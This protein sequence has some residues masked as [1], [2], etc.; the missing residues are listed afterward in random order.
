MT[1]R[2]NRLPG[3]SPRSHSDDWET[4]FDMQHYGI[5]TRLLDWSENLG[6]AAFF[7]S[8]FRSRHEVGS[9]IAIYML[10]P[11]ILN[12]YSGIK[13]LPFIPDDRDTDYKS[14]YW[15]KKPF[16]PV[17]PIAIE[18]IFANERML[19]QRGVFTVHGDSTTPI[20]ELCPKAVKRIVLTGNAIPELLEFLE[21]ANINEFTV[22]PDL[23]G[24]AD[25]VRRSADLL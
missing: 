24:I 15:E 9:D 12:A 4:L 17:Y 18:P 20:Q 1:D 14:I 19:A 3:L 8:A 6:I 22:Y 5:P 21:I 2:E 23:S 10:N 7:A 11:I 25:Y 16:A 13:R